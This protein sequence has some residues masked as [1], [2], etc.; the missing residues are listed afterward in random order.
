MHE[1]LQHHAPP[2]SLQSS[3]HVLEVIVRAKHVKQLLTVCLLHVTEEHS[4][5]SLRLK[6]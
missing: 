6:V 1:K 3:L 5:H 4:H 2:F